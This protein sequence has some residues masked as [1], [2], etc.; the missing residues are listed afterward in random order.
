MI[1]LLVSIVIWIYYGVMFILMFPFVLLAYLITLPFDK[2]HR[3]PNWVFLTLGRLYVKTIPTWR[4]HTSGLSNYNR[5]DS[6]IFISNHQSFMDMPVQSLLPWKFKWVSKKSLFYIPFM[7][8]NMSL[9]GHISIDRE[10][11]TAIKALNRMIP[12]LKRHIP[13]I[14]FPE[15][16]RSRDGQLHAFKNGAFSIA[17][18]HNVLIQ[19]IVINGTRNLLPS[20]DW[21]FNINQDI[22]ISVLEPLNPKNYDSI[23]DLRKSAF[24]LMNKEL[25]RIR[26]NEEVEESELIAS[27]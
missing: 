15:G 24:K 6:V 19:P 18:K 11:K 1:R 4:V 8:W 23:S 20:D 25:R 16:T 21:R 10:K 9:T 12:I 22:H 14:I 5:T 27:N 7:G 3:V 2:Y 13:I 17:A 26:G